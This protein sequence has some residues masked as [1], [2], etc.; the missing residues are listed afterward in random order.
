MVD[1][2]CFTVAP[3]AGHYESLLDCGREVAA[4]DVVGYLH[5]FDHIDMPPWPA[6][7]GVDGI[8]IA[9][10]WAAPVMRAA[11]RRGWQ[12][13]NLTSNGSIEC[14]AQ[15]NPDSHNDPPRFATG[16]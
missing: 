1:R 2:E 12:E 14:L 15:S 13:R 11:H 10:A 4:G 6:T 5:D 9:Q 3:F 16:C 8:V 7:A